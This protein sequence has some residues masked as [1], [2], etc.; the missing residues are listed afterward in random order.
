ME[1]GTTAIVQHSDSA[2]TPSHLAALSKVFSPLVMEGLLREGRSAY[3]REVLASSGLRHLGGDDTTVSRFL[4]CAYE[5]LLRNYRCE[6]VYKN[7][8]AS[9]IL[10][11]RHSLSTA[12]MFTELRVGRSKAD[13]VVLNGTSTVYEIK[14]E[15]DSMYR[16]GR[17]LESYSKVFDRINVI[18]SPS[19]ISQ[20]DAVV[21]AHVGIL[22]LTDRRTISTIRPAES[23]LCAVDAHSLFGLLRQPEYTRILHGYSGHVP[24]VPNGRFYAACRDVFEG[25]PAEE[26]H[27]LT[28]TEL[29]RR[30]SAENLKAQDITI[31]VALRAYACSISSDVRRLR[32]LTALLEMPL[33]SILV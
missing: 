16:L 19:Q 26:A 22:V 14:S 27:R 4:A 15:F 3:L 18:T 11:G 2:Q 9:K 6:Y 31:P 12:Q 8:I 25:I 13:V 5:Q 29:S 21:P 30:F 1:G 28:M 33:K 24:N 7:E 10:M 23:N 20:V 17:Q 32:A